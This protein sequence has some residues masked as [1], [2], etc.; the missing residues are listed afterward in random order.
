MIV[1]LQQ[2]TPKG[3][4][5]GCKRKSIKDKTFGKWKV[6]DFYLTDKRN[7]FW[8]CR[9]E[10]GA[11]KIVNRCSLVNGESKSCGCLKSPEIRKKLK[12]KIEIDENGCWNFLGKLKK[13][14]Y[15]RMH[16]NGK[17]YPVHRLSYLIFVEYV[18]DSKLICHKCDNRK[19]L[20]PSHLY[21]GTH[22]DNTRD[23][24]E[25]G[26]QNLKIGESHHNAKFK[27]HEILTFRRLH[28]NGVSISEISKKYSVPYKTIHK[29]ISRKTWMHV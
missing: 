22:A 16:Y 12:S 9:C 11:E 25:R 3:N 6:L 27:E 1:D 7:S 24:Y 10:C 21:A 18:E 19:C 23:M 2:N 29:I 8:I 14:G 28:K 26:R 13:D 17:Y 15:G 5:L 4:S 20:N